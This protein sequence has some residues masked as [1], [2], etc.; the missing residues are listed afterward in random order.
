VNSENASVNASPSGTLKFNDGVVGRRIRL[1]FT[2]TTSAATATPVL[3]GFALHTSWRPDRLK[4]WRMLAG[5]D[6][7]ARNLHGQ[8][9][10]LPMAKMLSNLEA[11]RAETSPIKFEDIDGVSHNAHIVDMAETQVRVRTGTAG[12]LQ[13]SRALNLVM[14][15]VPGGGWGFIRWDAFNWG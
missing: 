9:A 13:Y 6:S 15:E 12:T 3:K 11:L 1:R 5:L 14:T 10:M 4:T 7:A 8:R 2:L